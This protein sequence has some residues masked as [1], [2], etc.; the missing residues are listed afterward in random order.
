MNYVQTLMLK[1]GKSPREA[2]IALLDRIGYYAFNRWAVRQGLR[3]EFVLSIHK[4][5]AYQK[6][7][8]KAKLEG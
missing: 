1:E 6:K 4:R 7:L 2:C 3:L 5:L 8:D